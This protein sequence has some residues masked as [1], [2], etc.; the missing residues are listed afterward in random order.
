MELQVRPY[1]EQVFED[2]EGLCAEDVERGCQVLCAG[3]NRGQGSME[4]C[5][6]HSA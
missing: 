4:D 5:A 6:S 1:L 2:L 3:E